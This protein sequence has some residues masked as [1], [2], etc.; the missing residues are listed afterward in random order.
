MKYHF[1]GGVPAWYK[2][3]AASENHDTIL[4]F[5]HGLKLGL[6]AY[7]WWKNGV[8]YVGTCGHTLADATAV[9]DAEVERVEAKHRDGS[10]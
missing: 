5:L 4:S 6:M 8:Q 10:T 3:S 1:G 7:A 9:V 2:C